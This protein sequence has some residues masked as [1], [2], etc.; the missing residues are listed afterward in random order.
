VTIEVTLAIDPA[1]LGDGQTT[2][3]VAAQLLDLGGLMFSWT[4]AL[5]GAPARARFRLATE[6]DLDRFALNPRS[7]FGR[8][9]TR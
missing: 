6:S 7:V 3:I 4:P 1:G 8:P 5:E 9:L 2:A